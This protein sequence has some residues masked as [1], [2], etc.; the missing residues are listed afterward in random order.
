MFWYN[1]P[2]PSVHIS[3]VHLEG[4]RPWILLGHWTTR[5]SMWPCFFPTPLHP[6]LRH[7]RAR[8]VPATSCSSA[9]TAGCPPG[10]FY[11]PMTHRSPPHPLS[12]LST[13]QIHLQPKHAESICN[14]MSL[15]ACAELIK[16]SCY[17]VE[18]VTSNSKYQSFQVCSGHVQAD[19]SYDPLNKNHSCVVSIAAPIGSRKQRDEQIDDQAI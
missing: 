15:K 2:A 8:C 1:L 7:Q 3:A 4:L 19:V 16:L 14:T 12:L 17:D 6:V 13:Q 11:G 10:F 9:F 18:F 5:G